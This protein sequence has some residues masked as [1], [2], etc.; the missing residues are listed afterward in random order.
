M[1]SIFHRTNPSV[2]KIFAEAGRPEK[3]LCIPIDYAKSKHTALACNG[4]SEQL[5]SPFHLEN[6]PVGVA[7]LLKLTQGLCRK[8][9]INPAHVIYGGEDCGSY[10]LNFIHALAAEPGVVL[11]FHAAD[12]ADERENLQ[13]STDKLDL[14]GIANL[15][16]KKRGRTIH[17]EASAA[18]T[19]R[20]LT[21]HRRSLVR[22]ASSAMRRI[23]SLVDQ[24]MP[25]FLDE[26]QS[27]LVPFGRASLWLMSERFSPRQIRARRHD[28]L[29]EKLRDFNLREPEQAVHKLL[30]L[31]ER[32]LSP[33][34]SLV[35]AMQL[36]LSREVEVYES[37]QDNIHQL[38]L[39]IARQ[40]A[41]TPGAMLTTIRGIGIVLAAGLYAEVGDPA[42]R[43]AVRRMCSL[44]GIVPRVKQTGGPDRKPRA[45]RPSHRCNHILKDYILQASVGMGQYGPDELLQDYRRRELNGQDARHGSARKLLRI[46]LRLIQDQVGYAPGSL[47]K[48]ASPEQLREHYSSTWRPI[49]IKWANAGAITQAFGANAPLEQWRQMLEK[50]YGLTLSKASPQAE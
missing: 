18:R 9:H 24:L 44:A 49:L 1:N 19:L 33:P 37:L 40:L 22:A 3:V 5:H 31:S 43:Q 2:E 16:F 35:A 17:L 26:K 25:G 41:A 14:L 21:R 13:A 32:V 38:E 45:F 15:M 6:N 47:L 46:C 11:G 42:R 29:V 10:S 20:Q 48:S 12:A 27:G 8:H 39:A 28:A 4:A 30:A 7:F 36:S 34:P 50:L 23:H